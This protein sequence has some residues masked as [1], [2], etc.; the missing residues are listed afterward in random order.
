GLTVPQGELAA[1]AAKLRRATHEERLRMPTMRAR[2]ADL[3]PTGAL[4]LTTLLS[5]L[6]L[7]ELVVSDWGLRE[8]VLLERMESL[9]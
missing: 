2:R 3:L 8:G 6:A 1:L 4:I 9:A 7:A 5:E